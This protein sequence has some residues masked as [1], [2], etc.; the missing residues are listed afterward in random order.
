MTGKQPSPG[1]DPS[2]LPM[3]SFSPGRCDGGGM[4]RGFSVSGSPEGECAGVWGG[5]TTSHALTRLVPREP[6]WK[7]MEHFMNLHAVLAQGPG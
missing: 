6:K 1:Q 5:P 4:G 7:T 3:S 2:P